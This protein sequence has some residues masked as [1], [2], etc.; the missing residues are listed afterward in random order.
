MK[1][2]GMAAILAV[3][4]GCAGQEERS[5]APV[6][7]GDPAPTR[8]PAPDVKPIEGDDDASLESWR[9]SVLDRAD[10]ETLALIERDLESKIKV[11]Q[12]RDAGL[13]YL[14]PGIALEERT[15]IARRI[16]YENKRLKLV[17]TRR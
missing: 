17:R 7:P 9:S 6:L 13:S 1:A 10:D 3:A 16:M 2:W 8:H 15:R 5:D 4:A 14:P 12:D 11:L